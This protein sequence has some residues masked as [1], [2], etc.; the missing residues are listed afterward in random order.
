[1]KIIG[2]SSDAYDHYNHNPFKGTA[3]KRK[4]QRI[5]NR[6]RRIGKQL[7]QKIFDRDGHK[8]VSCGDTESLTLDHITPIRNGGTTIESNLQVMCFN[9]NAK[10]G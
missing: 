6:K 3:E 10:K 4:K 1:M 2:Y 8:C 5:K 9:C 7:K